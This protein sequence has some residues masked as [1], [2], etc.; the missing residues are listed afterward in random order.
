M[1]GCTFVPSRT[2]TMNKFARWLETFAMNAARHSIIAF[3][4]SPINNVGHT[5][6]T[7]HNYLQLS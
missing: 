3:S 6:P 4:L 5:A 2:F 7:G 1:V